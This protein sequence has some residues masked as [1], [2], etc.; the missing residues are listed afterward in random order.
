MKTNILIS[1]S[2]LIFSFGN[3]QDPISY[4]PNNS[5]AN[6]QLNWKDNIPRIRY[7]GDG[8]GSANGFQ[9][10]GQGDDVKFTVLNNGS[11][12]I[13]TTSPGAKLHVAHTSRM[14]ITLGGPSTSSGAVGDV[15]FKTKDNQT[16]GGTTYW[17]W[18]FRTDSWSSAPGD[19]VLYSSN[20]TYTSPI[21]AQADGDL[22]FVTGNGSSRN[23]NVGIGTTNPLS[24][25][26]I[27]QE[28]KKLLGN[29]LSIF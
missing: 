25:L 11:V 13:G 6:V 23:G 19:L 7:G 27:N 1:I 15:C 28:E 17:N 4:N 2:V 10:Q 24:K 29:F 14:S 21:I 22:L 8:P 12:G 16:V 3:A 26:S 20:G 18:S 9:I 5:S